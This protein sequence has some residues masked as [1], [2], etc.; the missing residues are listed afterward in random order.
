MDMKATKQIDSPKKGGDAGYDLR[1]LEGVIIPSGKARSVK[2]AAVEIPAGWCGLIVGRGLL[3]GSD[4]YSI[5]GLIDSGYRDH[6]GVFL[7]NETERAYTITAGE[8]IA[9]LL[10]VPF[11]SFPLEY[12]ESKS[13]LTPSER[14]DTGFGS[15]GKS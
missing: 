4:I 3:N 13:D 8:R 10:L 5:L 2:T 9:Q 14:G 1:A 15:T 11:G 7:R 6:I 12:V